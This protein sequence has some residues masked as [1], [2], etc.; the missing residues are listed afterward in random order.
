M[1]TASGPA[2]LATLSEL[3]RRKT[4]LEM[5]C[6]ALTSCPV[7]D[8]VTA[9]RPVLSS[10]QHGFVTTTIWLSSWLEE[11]W[12]A[13][14]KYLLGQAVRVEVDP[15]E[16][17]RF[18]HVLGRLRTF[19]AHNLDP[20]KTR[21][22]GTRDTCYAWF[23]DACGSSVPGDDQ[24]EHCLEALLESA[25]RCLQ[26]AIEVARAIERHADSVTLSNMWRDRLS[27]TDVVV[28]YLGELQRSAGDLGCEGLNLNQVRDR[29]SRRWAEA[30]SLIPAS[31]DL[32][33]ATTRHMEQALLA[34]T[35]RL[36]PVTAADVMERLALNP[37]E[38]VEVALR[39]GQVLYSLKPTLDRS[40][41]LDSLVENWDQLK[42]R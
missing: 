31:A 3:D 25:L 2:L 18:R 23:K 17:E 21:D 33:T 1:T 37:G 29:Y 22:R 14:M 41:L 34:E 13:S 10:P 6:D 28:N 36:L 30:L 15:A 9:P 19:F 12:K 27:R 16:A 35:G 32:D 39:L 24:W 42:V 8:P 40:S 5:L 11:A 4:E 7:G 38:S 26:L 20:G